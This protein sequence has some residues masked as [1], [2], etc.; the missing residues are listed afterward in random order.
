MNLVRKTFNFTVLLDGRQQQTGAVFLLYHHGAYPLNY[1]LR[2]WCIA[3][4]R[5]PSPSYPLES[6]CGKRLRVGKVGAVR[7]TVQHI[8]PDLFSRTVIND[9]SE[10]NHRNAVFKSFT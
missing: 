4:Q 9:F 2:G 5:D 8:A 6:G 1:S 10:L 7:F 3:L